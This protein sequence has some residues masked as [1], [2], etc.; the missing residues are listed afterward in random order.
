MYVVYE[1]RISIKFSHHLA[2]NIRSKFLK[3]RMP[4]ITH[5]R[6]QN[7]WQWP[8]IGGH[9]FPAASSSWRRVKRAIYRSIA[10]PWIEYQCAG[11]TI[12]LSCNSRPSIQP[13]S[14]VSLFFYFFFSFFQYQT[15]NMYLKSDIVTTTKKKKRFARPVWISK[16]GP[17]VST[18]DRKSS[19]QQGILITLARVSRGRFSNLNERSIQKREAASTQVDAQ[20]STWDGQKV[21]VSAAWFQM[22]EKLG[23]SLLDVSILFEFEERP[24]PSER[25]DGWMNRWATCLSGEESELSLPR[26]GVCW[27]S[28]RKR[29]RWRNCIKSW[30][31]IVV[32]TIVNRIRKINEVK[33]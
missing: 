5:N 32:G 23:I 16:R 28:I 15:S 33:I 6:Y 29:R 22:T 20:V 12:R 18:R 24:H 17:R 26:L 27:T 2:R 19:N 13:H 31:E 7:E 9:F 14:Y 8:L 4:R 1:A 3:K 25:G 10:H 30:L 21:C 11:A